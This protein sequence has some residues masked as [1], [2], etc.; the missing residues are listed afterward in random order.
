[1]FNDASRY[2]EDIYNIDNPKFEK[3]I[4]CANRIS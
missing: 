2:I 3:H 4:T 1:M